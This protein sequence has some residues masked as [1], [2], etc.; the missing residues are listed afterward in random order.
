MKTIQS[1]IIKINSGFI[2]RLSWMFMGEGTARITRLLTAVVLARYLT[3]AEF[4]VAALV[5]SVDEV[6]RV[7]TRNGVGQ[8]IIQ[9]QDFQLSNVCHRAYQLN[10]LIHILLFV[11]QLLLSKPLAVIFGFP[12]LQ[13]LLSVLACTYLIYPLSMVQVNLIQRDQNM[14]K[15]GMFFAAQVGTDNVLTAIFAFLGMGVWSIILPK[16][17]VAPLWVFL[18]RCNHSWRYKRGSEKCAWSD[19]VQYSTDVFGVEL[20][21]T[22]RQHADR[23]FIGFLLGMD[24]LGVYYFAVNAGSGMSQALIK[25]FTTVTLPDACAQDKGS[26]SFVLNHWVNVY[27][28][29]LKRYAVFILPLIVV[30][31]VTAPWY[32]PIIFG[33]QWV[34]AI[35]VLM[36]LCAA[37]IF[38]GMIDTGSQIFRAS[39]RTQPDLLFNSVFTV[40]FFIAIVVSCQL[41]SVPNTQLF[42]IAFA[43]L[44]NS[45]V[46]AVFHFILVKTSLFE[47]FK[48]KISPSNF[49]YNA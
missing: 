22:A 48:Q 29:A 38:Q 34:H 24:A 8:K 9:C 16:L 25:A 4:G 2:Q 13:N 20:L 47:A 19:I 30:Q 46:F 49:T 6:I 44:L 12:E 11:T 17:I 3:P 27:L 45:V 43:V 1:H 21:K 40:T 37:M 32:I 31:L 36:L 5:L 10:W 15:T 7:I 23:L 42:F 28:S 26:K 35:P 33:E 39:G 41:S 18:Y 14:K